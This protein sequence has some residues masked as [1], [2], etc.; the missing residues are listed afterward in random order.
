[1]AEKRTS[2]FKFEVGDTV[3]YWGGGSSSHMYHEPPYGGRFKGA[4]AQITARRLKGDRGSSSAF[5]DIITGY[6]GNFNNG[7]YDVPEEKLE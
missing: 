3:I 5:Y 7:I 1:M 2:P 6:S 4:E